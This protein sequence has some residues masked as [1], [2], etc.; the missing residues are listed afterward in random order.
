[1]PDHKETYNSKDLESLFKREERLLITLEDYCFRKSKKIE[2]EFF[3]GKDSFTL[4]IRIW[5]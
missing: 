3:V 4:K 5:N 2:T 1:M